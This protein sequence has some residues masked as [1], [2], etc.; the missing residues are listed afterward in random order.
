MSIPDK[1]FQF[2]SLFRHEYG[3][4]ILQMIIDE[5]IPLNF[6]MIME[7]L[8]ISKRG[9]YMTLKDLE[10]ENL[11]IQ[12]KIGRKSFISITET[13]KSAIENFSLTKTYEKKNRFQEIIDSTLAQ[14]EKEGIISNK[15]TPKDKKDF[16]EKLSKSIKNQKI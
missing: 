2:D 15:W 1:R 13:G 6:S 7:K 4:P 10:A 8:K 16:I 9:L 14:L 5:N 11:I 12:T 3:L